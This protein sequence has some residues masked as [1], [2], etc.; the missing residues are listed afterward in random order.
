MSYPQVS[1]LLL[2]W[3]KRK[4]LDCDF[5]GFVTQHGQGGTGLAWQNFLGKWCF[6]VP[7]LICS[8]AP[9]KTRRDGAGCRSDVL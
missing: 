7:A 9:G 4:M 3:L 1:T 6:V 2:V 5:F 8:A